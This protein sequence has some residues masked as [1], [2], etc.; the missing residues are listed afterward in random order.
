LLDISSSIRVIQTLLVNIDQILT[1]YIYIYME[2]EP[3]V[4][5]LKLKMA[6]FDIQ[7]QSLSIVFVCAVDTD[8][9]RSVPKFRLLTSI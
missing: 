2:Q 1:I 9:A 8:P 6:E 3:H 4:K 7:C 5:K